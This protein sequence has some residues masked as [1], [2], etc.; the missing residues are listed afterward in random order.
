M[1]PCDT[2]IR[3][4]VSEKE[5]CTW[6]PCQHAFLALGFLM[7]LRGPSL[8]KKSRRYA[9]IRDVEFWFSAKLWIMDQHVDLVAEICEDH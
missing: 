4:R 5:L 8:T 2:L 1:Q 7:G 3:R 6:R 9:N